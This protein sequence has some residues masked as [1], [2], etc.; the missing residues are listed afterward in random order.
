MS[1]KPDDDDTTFRPR[2]PHR[3]SRNGCARCKQRRVKCDELRPSCSRCARHN[4]RCY[5]PTADSNTALQTDAS[6]NL[7]LVTRQTLR[8]CPS[9]S[10]LTSLGPSLMASLHLSTLSEDAFRSSILRACSPPSPLSSPSKTRWSG[11]SLA[12]ST[13]H[14][15]SSA[16]LKLLDYYLAHTCHIIS[17]DEQDH[18]TLHT[19]IPELAMRSRPLMSSLLALAAACECCDLIVGFTGKALDVTDTDRILDLLTFSE[20]LH[21]ESLRGVQSL[22]SDPDNRAC[23]LA[24]AALIAIYGSASHQIRLWLFNAARRCR[25]GPLPY[26]LR[27]FLV[28]WITLFRSV[29]VAY[30]GLSDTTHGPYRLS[31]AALSRPSQAERL[32]ITAQPTTITSHSLFEAVVNTWGQAL[33]CLRHR[34]EVV[35]GTNPSSQADVCLGALRALSSIVAELF[36]VNH[37]L[38]LASFGG[39]QTPVVPLAFPPLRQI[40]R[41]PSW[42][43][44]YLA[45]ATCMA[46]STPLRRTRIVMAFANKIPPQFLTIVE[47]SLSYMRDQNTEGAEESGSVSAYLL[48]VDILAHWLV[49]VM[50]LDGLWWIGETG[51]WELEL[52]VSLVRLNDW[53]GQI[54]KVGEWWPEQM[55]SIREAHQRAYFESRN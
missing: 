54:R 39:S 28:Q 48:A 35:I 25:S 14:D 52:V 30:T 31:P 38:P 13:S 36:S 22:I 45:R 4:I 27:P 18:Y 41:V 9:P 42:L 23:V 50:L 10:G 29:Y 17:F 44:M 49:F 47:T 21:G 5:Y 3:K 51:A 6:S 20:R 2:R 53:D 7:D 43:Q 19:G 15:M 34:A 1:P 26:V 55:L 40:P 32:P 37:S 46:P 33:S 24:N 11:L 16:E 8:S 12:A